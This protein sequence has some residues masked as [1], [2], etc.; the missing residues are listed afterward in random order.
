M[1]SWH[2]GSLSV[3]SGVLVRVR[4]NL[5]ESTRIYQN[6][7]ES[8]RIYQNLPESCKGWCYQARFGI[9]DFAGGLYESF[10]WNQ[11]QSLFDRNYFGTFEF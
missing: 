6:L 4:Q 7:P 3:D 1:E 10:F 2:W 11:E 9:L 8:T 5:P